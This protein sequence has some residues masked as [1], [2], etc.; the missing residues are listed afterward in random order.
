MQSDLQAAGKRRWSYFPELKIAYTSW[1]NLNSG[2]HGTDVFLQMVLTQNK[3]KQAVVVS[4]HR[5]FCKKSEFKSCLG[6]SREW[7]HWFHLIV[8]KEMA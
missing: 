4:C 6:N 8:S 5:N 7:Y 1:F 3:R 2:S